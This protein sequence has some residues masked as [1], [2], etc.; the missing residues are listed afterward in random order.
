V[1]IGALFQSF[2]GVL[3]NT[4]LL[5]SLVRG[6]VFLYR[7]RYPGAEG[8]SQKFYSSR[9][10]GHISY[11]KTQPPPMTTQAALQNHYN[12]TPLCPPGTEGPQP[13]GPILVNGVPAPS[14]L[15]TRGSNVHP[16]GGLTL[17]GAVYGSQLQPH[18]RPLAGAGD[19]GRLSC[20]LS[21]KGW[22]GFAGSMPA[23]ILGAPHEFR[24]L[25]GLA[26][27]HG[28]KRYPAPYFIPMPFHQSLR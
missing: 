2:S 23:G 15:P 20:L 28:V 17:S 3:K 7:R 16:G 9:Y 25:P 12:I 27:T 14:R 13:R 11:L 24:A 6:P 21:L 10:R 1:A 26:A 18:Q 8:L 5:N 22:P 19:P 4:G